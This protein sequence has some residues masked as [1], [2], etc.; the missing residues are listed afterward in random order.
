MGGESMIEL[1]EAMTLARQMNETL[2]GKMVR[3][4]ERGNAP[5]KF[6]FYSLPAEDYAEL[7][8]GKTIGQARGLGSFI[9]VALEPGYDLVLGDGGER[10]I[11]HLSDK[12]LPARHQLLLSFEDDSFLTVT[13]QMWGFIQLVRQG[14]PGGDT[15]SAKEKVYPLG[16][17]FNIGYFS[18]LFERLPEG[19]PGSVKYFMISKPGVWG[20]GNGYLQDILFRA[21]LHPRR[22]AVELGM[23]ER[24]A[25]YTAT[26]ETLQQAVDA[27]GRSSEL[28]LYGR[29][30][31]YQKTLDS[32][33]VG[34]PCPVCTTPI[35]KIQFLGG[36]AYFCPH[37]QP[38]HP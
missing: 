21:R 8:R 16:D 36:A 32:K 37:C 7:C 20:V 4:C 33:S 6:A 31:G 15:S 23:E 13:V 5:H 27:G 24:Q 2:K 14:E 1:P 12:T 9:R 18:Q 26:R 38:E 34:K 10:I 35:E 11:L 17:E 30:G 28:D 29:P 3:A 25:L 19:D 22:R